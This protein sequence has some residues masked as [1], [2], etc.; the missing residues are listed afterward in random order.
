MNVLPQI[1][2]QE[3]LSDKNER[4]LYLAG[5]FLEALLSNKSVTQGDLA[6]EMYVAIS[7]LRL[8]GDE[9]DLRTFIVDYQR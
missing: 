4:L 2:S 6:D 9:N 1:S 8:K 7:S 5:Y 3:I